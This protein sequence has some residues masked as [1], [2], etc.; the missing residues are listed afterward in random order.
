MHISIFI[1]YASITLYK[2]K[3]G[4]YIL[5]FRIDPEEKLDA[6][7]KE[8]QSF[9]A[10]YLAS[11]VFGVQFSKDKSV[12]FIELGIQ[13]ILKYYI[14]HLT[15]IF[16]DPQARAEDE[17]QEPVQDDII[18]DQQQMRVDAFAVCF[19]VFKKSVSGWLS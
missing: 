19:L 6:T 10:A 18:I 4:E 11:P 14:T 1:F 2:S 12:C 9:H 17:Q 13:G 7:S 16:K 3:S 15:I 8:I 5:G